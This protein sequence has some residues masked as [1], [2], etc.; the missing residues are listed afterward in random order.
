MTEEEF[1]PKLQRIMA[2]PLVVSAKVFTERGE[3]TVQAAV[4]TSLPHTEVQA[5]RPLQLLE[6]RQ[7]FVEEEKIWV[8][9]ET[10]TEENSRRF[11]AEVERLEKAPKK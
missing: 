4:N 8:I 2:N 7:I 10:R 1:N 11:F 5:G 3:V 9:I 6:G